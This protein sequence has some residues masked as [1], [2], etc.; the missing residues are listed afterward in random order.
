VVAGG[1]LYPKAAIDAKLAEYQVHFHNGIFDW[2][3]AALARAGL[4]A[5]QRGD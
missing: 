2:V 3:T 1:R 4:R 5:I